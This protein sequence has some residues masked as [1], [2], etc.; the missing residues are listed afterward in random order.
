MSPTRWALPRALSSSCLV[1]LLTV[2]VL[3]AGARPAAAQFYEPTLRSLDLTNSRVARSPRLLGMGGLAL[4]I[5]DRDASIDLWDFA[6]I[7]VGLATDDTVSSLDLRPSTDALS[8]VRRLPS[9]LDR[10]NLAARTAIA[11]MEAVYRSRESGSVFGVIGDLSGLRWDRPYSPTIERREGLTH[12]EVLA[13][14]GGRFQK[15]VGGNMRWATH[16]RFRG[17]KVEDRYRGIVTNGAGEWL[18]QSGDE[19]PPPSEFEPTDV[20]VNTTAYGVSTGFDIGAASK[21]ALGLER[22]N[23][24]IKST[25][26]LHRSSAEYSEPRGYWVGQ[27]AFVTGLGRTF[28]V[29]VNGIGRL[30]NSEA[31]WRFTASAGVGGIPLTGRGN[32]LNREERSSELQAHAR[33][34]PGAVT[35]AGAIF[36]AASEVII[37]PPNANDPTS[38]NRF[39]HEAFQRGGADTLSF[40]DSVSHGETDRRAWGWG[41]GASMKLGDGTLG[42]ELHWSRDV[43]ATTL[44]G[45][46]PRRIAW[47]IRTGYEQ[48]LGTQ[49]TGRL[50]YGYRDVDEDDYTANN[51]FVGHA[52]SLGIGFVPVSAPWSAQAGYVIEVRNQDF[53]SPADE[54][55]TRQ[56]LALHL[57]W[58]F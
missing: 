31:D 20:R 58:S 32:L 23:N 16:L 3:C 27:A 56:N 57:H 13:V 41:G 11:Q 30:S 8:S 2:P 10:Q 35:L 21:F 53:A 47:D 22:E 43:R 19:L 4:V 15:F 49:L 1:T 39:I 6:R 45:S 37:D 46:G 50:G 7:P 54:R 44:A 38:L 12:P 18:D 24:E 48:P 25:N 55:Q 28:E 14:L 26:E 34:S 40:P 42:A 29:G 36:T 33:W 51:E 9:G 5:P 52:I 17:E